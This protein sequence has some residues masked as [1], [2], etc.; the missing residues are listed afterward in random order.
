MT[1]AR[2]LVVDDEPMVMDVLRRYLHRDGFVVATAGDGASALGEAR[3]E[4]PDLVILDLMLPAIDG[5]AVCQA[6]RR[7]SPVP[8]LMLTAR[9][10]EADKVRGLKLGADD[11]VVKPFSPNEVVARVK[12]LLRRASMGSGAPEGEE[13][14]FPGLSILP[15]SRTVARDGVAIDVTATEFDL[16]LHMARHPRRVFTRE[17]LLDAL[18]DQEFLGEPSTITVHIRRLRMKVEVDP[19]QPRYLKTVWG[20]GYKFDPGAP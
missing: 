1:P 20:V 6:L 3:R 17:Q 8:I 7:W 4:M 2:I 11:Y 9:G 10:E 14:R 18:W 12:A 5:L 15:A 19:A 16:L 13:L